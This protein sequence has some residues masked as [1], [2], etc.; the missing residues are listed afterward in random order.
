MVALCG[1]AK[2]VKFHVREYLKGQLDGTGITRTY[3]VCRCGK[4]FWE[5]I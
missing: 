1:A 5:A 4:N 3:K 2:R